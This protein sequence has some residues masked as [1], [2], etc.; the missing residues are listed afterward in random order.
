MPKKV[1]FTHDQIHERPNKRFDAPD[2]FQIHYHFRPARPA[3]FCVTRDKRTGALNV[4][5][6]TIGPLTWKPYTMCLHISIKGS[7]HTYNNLEMGSEC[8]IALPGRN[9]IKETWVTA[10]PILAGIS[11]LDVAGLHESPS[12]IVKTPGI[13]ECPVNFECV[14]EFKQDYY[15]HGI[16]FVRVLGA[17]IDENIL[18]MSREEVVRY[19]PTYEVDDKANKFG[20]SI[21]RLGV[22]GEIFE[23]PTFP[24]APKA[25]W[26]QSF[27]IWMKD[28]AEEQYLRQEEFDHIVNLR[29]EYDNLYETGDLSQQRY[30]QLKEYFT[31]L[32]TYIIND[33]WDAVHNLIKSI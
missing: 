4:S 24:S 29:K 31:K 32:P 25:G 5:A 10:L 3:N 2:P 20:G 12:N 27:D 17:S 14:V 7:P 15:T 30:L 33:R 19:Y 22:M 28:L 18:S 6:G 11:E 8:V 16:I 23:C 1:F 13:A 9:I 21:E 26:Y